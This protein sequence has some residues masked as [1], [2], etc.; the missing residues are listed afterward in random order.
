MNNFAEST[1]GKRKGERKR[2]KVENRRGKQGEGDDTD[3]K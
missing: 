2:G 1:G 3:L